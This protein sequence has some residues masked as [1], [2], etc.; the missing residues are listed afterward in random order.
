M[1]M[2]GMQSHAYGVQSEIEFFANY[3]VTPIDKLNSTE[4]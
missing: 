3:Y 4:K 2:K 1:Q